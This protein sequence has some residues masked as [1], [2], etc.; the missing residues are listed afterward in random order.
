MRTFGQ[1][2]LILLI[3]H[4][5]MA[6]PSVSQR[7]DKFMNDEELMMAVE[8]SIATNPKAVEK[9][10]LAIYN[11]QTQDEK[12]E[13]TTKYSNGI[14]FSGA[15]VSLGGYLAGWLLS[16]KHLSGKFLSKGRLL[17]YK[18]RGQLFDIAKDKQALA[19][20]ALAHQESQKILDDLTEREAI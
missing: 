7:G 6:I 8:K 18:Y 15:D 5:T 10:I 20:V 12:Q 13:R 17:A 3:T 9:A 14:G 19:L 16:G 4:P 11:R 1:R 2:A